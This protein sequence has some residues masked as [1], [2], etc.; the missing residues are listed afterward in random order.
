MPS[1][2]EIL[3][4][5]SSSEADDEGDEEEDASKADSKRRAGTVRSGTMRAGT[6]RAGTVRSSTMRSGTVR[7]PS[8][9]STRQDPV[10]EVDEQDAYVLEEADDTVL[11]LLDPTALKHVTC[12]Y[13]TAC[14]STLHH[15]AFLLHPASFCLW[16]VFSSYPLIRALAGPDFRCWALFCLLVHI[17]L[18]CLLAHYSSISYLSHS[19][20]S[21]QLGASQLGCKCIMHHASQNA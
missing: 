1:V 10:G 2:K 12:I 18:A 7:A 16:L 11:D 4:S 13:F 15:S 21:F 9:R 20:C 17:L 8:K 3:E 19:S 14:T 6:V 5:S